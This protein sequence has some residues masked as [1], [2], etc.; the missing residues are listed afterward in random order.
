MEKYIKALLKIT[1]EVKFQE[2]LVKGLLYFRSIADVR[3]V[4]DPNDGVYLKIDGR[5]CKVPYVIKIDNPQVSLQPVCCFYTILGDDLSDNLYIKLEKQEV[6]KLKKSFGNYVTIITDVDGF[7]NKVKDAHP[8]ISYGQCNYTNEK[9]PEK[10][11]FSKGNSFSDE[12]EYRFLIEDMLINSPHNE[13]C[14]DCYKDYIILDKC[15]FL[16]IG[17]ISHITQTC[18]L[19]DLLKGVFVKVNLPQ[20]K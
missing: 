10:I 16:H 15:F 1:K 12:Q 2:D 8:K 3:N 14:I 6:S 17:N 18:T 20:E 13:L 11:G 5:H 9:Y 19:D 7:I 4:N